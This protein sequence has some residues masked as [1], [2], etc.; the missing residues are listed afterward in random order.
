MQLLFPLM[1]ETSCNCITVSCLFTL[2]VVTT[3]FD[4]KDRPQGEHLMLSISIRMDAN[5]YFTINIS[6]LTILCPI[7]FG[8]YTL[9]FVLKLLNENI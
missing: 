4:L 6:G 7:K 2:Q 5:K 9:R 8:Q 3:S 1:K